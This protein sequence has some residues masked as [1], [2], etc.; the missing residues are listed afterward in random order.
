MSHNS[1]AAG[2][3]RKK[4]NNEFQKERSVGLLFL[5]P[6]D[7][8]EE[9]TQHQVVDSEAARGQRGQQQPHVDEVLL[10]ERHVLGQ[11]L[12]MAAASHAHHVLDPVGADLP[13]RH[14][15]VADERRQTVGVALVAVAPSGIVFN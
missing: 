2:S 8:S 7:A 12:Q 13:R 15:L 3:T 1:L 11:K 4:R 14:H 5:G 6:E 10:V 9:A